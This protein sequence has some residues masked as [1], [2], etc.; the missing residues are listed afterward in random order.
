VIEGSLGANTTYTHAGQSGDISVSDL[1][2]ATDPGVVASSLGLIDAGWDNCHALFQ[3]TEEIRDVADVVCVEG[4]PCVLPPSSPGRVVFSDGDF[5]LNSSL[6]GAG[7]L[8]VTGTL[9][10][11]GATDWNGLIVVVG[12]GIF[13]RSGGG[14]GQISGAT[15][16][17][18]IAG[19]DDQYGTSDDCEGGTDGFDSAVYDESAG[20]TGL[21]TYCNADVLAAT[22]LTKYA[23]VDFR[24]R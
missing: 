13:L 23:V 18:D 19:A 5:S 3:M 15:I 24:Q 11:D 10:V 1:T 2:D 12:E 9:T 8:W 22:P 20:G 4:V 7:L 17:A 16:V 14:T 21:T 6:S